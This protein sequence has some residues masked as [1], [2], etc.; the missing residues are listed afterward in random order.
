MGQ[1][2]HSKRLPGHLAVWHTANL[3]KHAAN[4]MPAVYA[5][6]GSQRGI[7]SHK[8][9]LYLHR[10]KPGYVLLQPTSLAPLSRRSRSLQHCKKKSVAQQSASLLLPKQ[11]IEA[12][13][14]APGL[15][16]GKG[17]G[18]EPLAR[19]SSVVCPRRQ[20]LAQVAAFGPGD[21]VIHGK[22]CCEDLINLAVT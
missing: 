1:T 5:V 9:C 22:L 7:A 8:G 6:C 10:N 14:A 21:C 2:D 19:D 12:V 17:D 20:L 13:C 11:C 3:C 18:H 15:P 16:P 4:W